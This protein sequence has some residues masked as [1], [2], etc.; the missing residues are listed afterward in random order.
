MR[1]LTVLLLAASA[2]AQGMPP[3][4][5]VDSWTSPYNQKRLRFEWEILPKYEPKKL[6]DGSE[7]PPKAPWP[8]LVYVVQNESKANEK[9]R[10]KVLGDTRFVLASHAVKVVRLKPAK[11][12]D[13][14]YLA[15]VRG[16]RDPTLILV[17]RDFQVLEVMNSPSDFSASKVLGMLSKAVKEAYEI[18][19]GAY[20]GKYVKLLKEGEKLWK[21]EKKMEDLRS[22]AG[23]A[24]KSKAAKYD[25]EADEIEKELKPKMAELADE[26]IAI[27]DSLVLKGTEEKEELPTHVGSGKKRRE[28]TPQEI[29]AIEAFKEFAR[30]DNPVV[31]AAAVEDLGNIDSAVMVAYILK[32]ANDVD[33]RVTQAAGKALGRMKSEEA[34]EAMLGGLT[35]GNSKGRLAALWGFVYTPRP[36]PAAVKPIVGM[37]RRGDD[38]TRRAAIQAL[39]NMKDA[40]AAPALIEALDDRLPGLRV[41]AA[42]ALGELKAKAAA[43]PLAE[44]LGASD[45]S[46]Q[47]AAAEAL[48]KIREK[49]SIEPLLQT[50]E[51][52]EGLLMEIVHKS[53]VA[54]TGQD[55]KYRP[56][57]WRKWWDRWGASFK[58]PTEAEIAE[59]KRK[60]AKALEGY[61]DPR[62]RRYHK[63]E[64]LSRKMI[65][66]IDISASMDDKIVIPPYAPQKVKD[67]FPNRVK[68]EIAK[69]ELIDLLATLEPHV[70]FNIIT[71]AGRVKTWKDNLVSASSRTSAI[72]YVSKLEAMKPPRGGRKQSSG[73]EQKT[74]T[75]GALMAAFGLQDEAVPNWKSR[76]DVDTIFFVTDGIPTTGEITDVRLLIDAI[77]EMNKSRGVV[78][79]V[80]VFDKQ[81]AKK[82]GPLA[83]RN[84]GQCVVRG[85]DPK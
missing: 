52:E 55:F 2:L 62:K 19:L 49:E 35:G 53:L 46:L 85:W 13:V 84:G 3:A 78:I 56:E 12:I 27:Q 33:V 14:P 80:V 77:T 29:E 43:G 36:Y 25:R 48:G 54:I 83:T 32:A 26:E 60:A 10:R 31:R 8:F 22:K 65:F 45:W 81:E 20:V 21:L 61:Y 73:E 57:N 37:L 63:I 9:L 39:Q 15:A 40:K 44:R 1:S 82:L 28:F 16:I 70:Y 47:K 50:F 18:R 4:S 38:E 58:V 72:K 59:M 17:D 64:T 76:S 67:E 30:D 51:K 79:H 74:N 6:P 34:L 66:V 75:Y 68:I 24:D 5:Q 23:E 69:K 42:T 11:A 7:E 71:F 41:M